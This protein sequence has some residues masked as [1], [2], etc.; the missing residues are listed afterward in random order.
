MTMDPIFAR[1]GRIFYGIAIA[2]TGLLTIYYRDFPYYLIPPNHGWLVDHVFWIYAS[3]IFLL[4]AGASIVFERMILP[5]SLLL[6]TVFLLIFLFYFI[7]YELLVSTKSMHFGAWENAAKTLA[8]A[9]GAFVI[10]DRYAASNPAAPPGFLQRLIPLG[11]A[12][13]PLTIISFSIDHF[14]YAREAAGYV[15]SW[16]SNPVFWLYF[17]GVA[18]CASGVAI[19]LK[20]IPRLS[21]GLLGTMIF[22]WVIILHIPKAMAAPL[23]I[24]GGEVTS[25]LLAL[26]YCGAAFVIAGTAPGISRLPVEKPVPKPGF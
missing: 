21:A 24:N 26:A 7:P 8:L 5:I 13:F 25:A 15:P 23:A 10:A 17:T 18:L 22:I 6:G 3:G 9:G 12:C 1:I 16:I 20:I 2:A 14:L 4:L 11:A 19:F